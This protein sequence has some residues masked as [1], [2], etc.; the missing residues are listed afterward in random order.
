MAVVLSLTSC[1]TIVGGSKYNA[2]IQVANDPDAHIYYKGNIV[3]T[4]NAVVKVKRKDADK[5][6]FSVQQEGREKQIYRYNS[7]TIRGWALAGTILGWTA[8]VSPGI[9]L[10]FGVV[11][12]A[13]TGAHWKPN[14][15][16][17][18]VTKDDYKNFRYLVNYRKGVKESDSFKELDVVYLK[19]GGVTKGEI[20]EQ[21]PNINIKIQTKDGNVFVYKME[22]ISK[23]S[24]EKVK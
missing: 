13:I 14:V 20:I 19:N 18:G 21:V 10:P 1:A 4:G 9:P 5:F 22:E 3:G 8:I 6:E 7:R 15:S 12:D 17:S 11:V 16:E 23:I 24:K 2:H